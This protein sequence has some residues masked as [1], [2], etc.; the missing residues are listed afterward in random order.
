MDR[1]LTIACA[2]MLS[3]CGGGGGGGSGGGGSPLIP[4]PSGGLSA[5]A[6]WA[7]SRYA[8]LWE[9]GPIINGTNYSKGMPARPSPHPDG[10]AFQFPLVGGSVNYVTFRHGSLKGKSRIAMQYRVE[11]AP[12]VRIVP[13]CC[14]DMISALTVYFQRRGDDWNSD[15]WRWWFTS[16]TV[17][18]IPSGPGE[19]AAP[20]NGQWTSVFKMSSS[21]APSQFQEAI[22]SADRVGF[23]F[24]GG[25]GY[26][27]GDYATGTATF[28]LTSFVVE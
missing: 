6:N 15:G 18:P 28:V 5:P 11:M 2:V 14:P 3:S 12:G 13:K 8:E 9:F 26:G 24:G 23:T 16:G 20:L 21:G 7:D 17:A 22:N 25:D 27:H 1:R 4:P 10:L 19:I